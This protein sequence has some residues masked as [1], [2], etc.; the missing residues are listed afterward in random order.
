VY[1]QT[2]GKA[3]DCHIVKNAD[4]M[5]GKRAALYPLC[6]LLRYMTDKVNHF[7]SGNHVASLRRRDA[8]DI[9]LSK[10]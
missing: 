1:L 6:D 3:P 4:P 2:S 7:D 10:H 8:P 9:S 5:K